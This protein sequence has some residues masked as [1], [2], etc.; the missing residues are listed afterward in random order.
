[1]VIIIVLTS[2]T[3]SNVSY[4][5]EMTKP[6]IVVG[7]FSSFTSFVSGSGFDDGVLIAVKRIDDVV[8]D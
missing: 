1:M 2:F 8:V 3:L 7:G 6:E 4:I 5:V